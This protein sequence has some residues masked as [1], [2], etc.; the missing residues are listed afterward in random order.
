MSSLKRYCHHPLELA[1]R[2][3][4]AGQREHYRITTINWTYATIRGKQDH[5]LVHR[6]EYV[7]TL[8][9]L[10]RFIRETAEVAED[11]IAIEAVKN[12]TSARPGTQRG[13]A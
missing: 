11:I 9:G 4:K 3:C 10:I 2:E 1:L 8:R 7:L 12:T 6:N 5:S 13:K